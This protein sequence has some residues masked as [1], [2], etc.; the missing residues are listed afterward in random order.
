MISI[1]APREGSDLYL[2]MG[3][4]FLD[5]SIHAPREG[6]DVC[7]D[8]TVAARMTISIHAPREGSDSWAVERA[9]R[10]L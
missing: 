8:R 9:C 10:R 5:I 3:F 4:S 1:H 6:S 2:L 7:S